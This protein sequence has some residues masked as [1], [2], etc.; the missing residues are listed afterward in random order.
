MRG[1]IAPRITNEVIHP[2]A[3]ENEVSEAKNKGLCT[4]GCPVA[5]LWTNCAEL[6]ASWR[7]WICGEKDKDEDGR[8]R[9]LNCQATCTCKGK[10]MNEPNHV[11]VT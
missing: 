4:N 7:E 8:Q 5:D 3:F 11:L 6:A 2:S 10:I 9:F 1:R